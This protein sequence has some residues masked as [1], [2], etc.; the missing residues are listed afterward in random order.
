MRLLMEVVD[1]KTAQAPRPRWA[2]GRG[3]RPVVHFVEQ[4]C[5]S[6][7]AVQPR[8]DVSSLRRSWRSVARGYGLRLHADV[9]AQK[10]LLL[11]VAADV[12][13]HLLAPARGVDQY[14]SNSTPS[15]RARPARPADARLELADNTGD[16]DDGGDEG[17]AE[18][19]TSSLQPDAPH[20]ACTAQGRS[21]WPRRCPRPRRSGRRRAARHRALPGNVAVF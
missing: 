19:S 8:Q 15:G 2:A 11:R 12:A 16:A 14:S 18:P 9:Q 3:V 10:V 17:R 4:A 21:A 1:R 7:R 5:C 6:R 13:L 20:D